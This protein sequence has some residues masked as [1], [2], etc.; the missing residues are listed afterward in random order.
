[1]K[2]CILIMVSFDGTNY[3]I[4][5]HKQNAKTREVNRMFA[6][7]YLEPTLTGAYNRVMTLK[8]ELEHIGEVEIYMAV[9]VEADFDA[10]HLRA[11]G[12]SQ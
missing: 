10:E 8:R 11:V 6:S 2:N 3:I 4:E 7:M 12:L 1:M 9:D 5:P